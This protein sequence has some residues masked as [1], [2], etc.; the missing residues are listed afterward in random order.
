MGL[1]ASSDEWCHRSDDAIHGIDG[2]TKLVDDVLIQ[3][4]S[5][6]ELKSR[7][8]QVLERC[9][10]H[11]ITISKRKIHVGTPLKFAGFLITQ[12]G[13]RPDPNKT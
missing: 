12:E 10:S 11:G 2:V 5:E 1:N 6:E 7:L 9:K 3:A 4:E 8:Y 13:I